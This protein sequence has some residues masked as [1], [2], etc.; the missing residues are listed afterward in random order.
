MGQQYRV[1]VIAR[2]ARNEVISNSDGTFKVRLTAPPAD[3][4]ANDMLLELLSNAWDVPKTHL[5]I[6]RGHT[7]RT[8][9]VEV[10]SP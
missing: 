7:S 1:K 9:T 3:G 6:T 5:R 4:K 10:L 2:A 8:K